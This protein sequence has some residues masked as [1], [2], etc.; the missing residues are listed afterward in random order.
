[1]QGMKQD[2]AKAQVREVGK[3]QMVEDCV[4]QANASELCPV[5][6]WSP[7]SG[8]HTTGDAQNDPLG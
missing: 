2:K 3:G 6:Y 1:M 5:V 4:R 7:N 8:V